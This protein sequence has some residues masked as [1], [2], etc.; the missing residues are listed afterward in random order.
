MGR[1]RI[2][3]GGTEGNYTIEVLHNRER[4]ED[5]IALIDFRLEQLTNKLEAAKESLV[6]A[7]LEVAEAKMLA[8]AL[9]D[10]FEEEGALPLVDLNNL[11]AL[12]NS[13]RAANGLD[14]LAISSQLNEAAQGH[15]DWL[16]ANNASGHTGVNGSNPGQ[17]I[18]QS[19]YPASGGE[20]V[21]VGVLPPESKALDAWMNSPGHR[22]NVLNEGYRH[23]GVGYA[24]RTD[25]PYRHFWVTV[26]GR[27]EGSVSGGSVAA[28]GGCVDSDADAPARIQEAIEELAEKSRQRDIIRLEVTAL[29]A[30]KLSDDLRKKQLEAIPADPI[31]Q[32][33]CA[34]Y[35]EDLAGEVAT[36]EIPG[37]GNTRVIVR[38]GFEGRAVVTPE[39]DGQLFHRPGMTGAQVFLAAALLP[40]WQKW[41]PTYRVG[42][43]TAVNQATDTASVSLD[44][45]VSSAQALGVNQSSIL[46]G[47]PVE[48]MDCD[49]FPFEVGDRVLV[50]FVGQQWSGAKVIGFESNPKECI[51]HGLLARFDSTSY[52]VRRRSGAWSTDTIAGTWGNI[53]YWVGG[54]TRNVMSFSRDRIHQK[55]VQLSYLLAFSFSLP[56]RQGGGCILAVGQVNNTRIVL[57]ALRRSSTT[58]NITLDI[59]TNTVG[60][61]LWLSRGTLNVSAT[62]MGPYASGATARTPWGASFDANGRVDYSATNILGGPPGTVRYTAQVVTTP[63]VSATQSQSFTPYPTLSRLVSTTQTVPVYVNCTG[64][65]IILEADILSQDW[66]VSGSWS[67]R[68]DKLYENHVTGETVTASYSTTHNLQATRAKTMGSPATAS[69]SVFDE[70]TV[71]I[72]SPGSSEGLT[73]HTWYRSES[74]S[75]A[76]GTDQVSKRLSRDVQFIMDPKNM[77]LAILRVETD[78]WCST[79]ALATIAALDSLAI[80]PAVLPSIG[81]GDGWHTG[82][83]VDY[84]LWDQANDTL[85]LAG[86]S[87]HTQSSVG[88]DRVYSHN[89]LVACEGDD[90]PFSSDLCPE[91]GGYTETTRALCFSSSPPAAHNVQVAFTHFPRDINGN[92]LLSML[93]PLAVSG[94]AI[95]V[96]A[97]P[98]NPEEITFLTGG[99]PTIVIGDPP[100]YRPVSVY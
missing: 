18:Q 46:T 23:I 9:I 99:D 30:D 80:T 77:A 92:S 45:A 8:D 67:D 37:E 52:L 11:V 75:I 2:V 59:R 13:T 39:R 26:F 53:G 25:G 36:S 82:K 68:V 7:D 76:A 24:C 64:D 43:V 66:E 94:Q 44:N 41:M 29:E 89:T 98:A 27:Y 54:N 86:G 14:A 65:G 96:F 58:G 61:S 48:Y 28:P 12:H 85:T 21:A 74:S 60:G 31:Q 49:A 79:G 6:Y 57:S 97:S 17:R 70:T 83:A 5:E 62:D 90:W 50:Q 88:P 4:I 56:I 3:S 32:A 19:G 15:A 38:P 22:S 73:F 20:N 33:W 34:D 69:G 16:A 10:T 91:G 40:G 100:P 78:Y 87:T 55:G 93:T 71:H 72:T 84:Y 47:I 42:T 95:D 35:T 51:A 1:A 63:T 81:P